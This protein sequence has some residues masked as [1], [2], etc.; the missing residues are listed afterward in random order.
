LSINKR[1]QK[2]TWGQSWAK[3]VGWRI[4]YQI[5]NPSLKDKVTAA[6]IYKPMSAFPIT[7]R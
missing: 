2:Y 7:P 6:F 4:D 5:I 3:N 1:S